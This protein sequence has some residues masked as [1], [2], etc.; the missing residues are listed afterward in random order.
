MPSI[1]M[2]DHEWGWTPQ[3]FQLAQYW[4][5][6]KEFRLVDQHCWYLG[7]NPHLSIS[8]WYQVVLPLFSVK[9]RFRWW[10]RVFCKTINK[11]RCLYLCWQS[12]KCFFKNGSYFKHPRYFPLWS[13][14]LTHFYHEKPNHGMIK[15]WWWTQPTVVDKH[16]A[17]FISSNHILFFCNFI[18][19]TKFWLL[20]LCTLGIFNIRSSWNMGNSVWGL[21]NEPTTRRC[22]NVFQSAWDSR[23]RTALDLNRS[24]LAGRTFR[25]FNGVAA[26]D[27]SQWQMLVD[28]SGEDWWDDPNTDQVIHVPVKMEHRELIHDS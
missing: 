5:H 22:T 20:A 2:C 7:L 19:I 16:A 6:D 26:D 10:I 8:I 14:H 3:M 24:W 4:R 18:S 11:K 9:R 15:T 21:L 23:R 12:F 25:C 27:V 13:D 17:N 1:P 28:D